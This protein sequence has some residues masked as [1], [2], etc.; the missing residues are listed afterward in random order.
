MPLTII[1]NDNIKDL[2]DKYII[3]QKNLPQPFRHKYIGEWDVSRVT[4]MSNLFNDSKY[5]AFNE[6]IN[7]WD[8]SNVTNMKSMFAGCIFFN[9]PLYKWKVSKVTDMSDMFNTCR[10]FNQDI[11]S[12]DVFN[13]KDM[14]RMFSSCDKLREKPNWVLNTETKT[15]NI[16]FK[17]AFE[18][19]DFERSDINIRKLERE[20]K[21][22]TMMT[23]ARSQE[24]TNAKWQK[25]INARSQSM[26]NASS[27]S[28]SNARSQ[29]LAITKTETFDSDYININELRPGV[30]YNFTYGIHIIEGTFVEVIDTNPRRL[31]YVFKDIYKF[32]FNRNTHVYEIEKKYSMN[33][34]FENL[35]RYIKIIHSELPGN[36]SKHINLVNVK[37]TDLNPGSRYIFT[38]DDKEYETEFIK[39]YGWQLEGTFLGKEEE[40][41]YF[42]DVKNLTDDGKSIKFVKFNNIN[43]SFKNFKEFIFTSVPREINDKIK[44][45]ITGLETLHRPTKTLTIQNGYLRQDILQDLVPGRRYILTTTMNG[46]E[47]RVQLR[48]IQKILPTGTVRETQYLFDKYNL[49][50]LPNLQVISKQNPNNEIFIGKFVDITDQKNMYSNYYENNNN[51]INN[52]TYTLTPMIEGGNGLKKTKCRNNKRR[53]RGTRKHYR[54]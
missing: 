4:D 44:S 45:Y 51:N 48:F 32:A 26:S 12:W 6:D 50:M 8:V 49:L 18:G 29:S 20:G 19:T 33:G 31:E 40:I 37:I 7:E 23:N 34:F 17:T 27:Q 54:L 16:F 15:E 30:R 53:I 28:M 25:M 11:S 42:A 21:N 38:L 43:N 9:K 35:I 36:P 47:H 52:V 41:Y 5:Y 46:K 39:K 24:M 3:D 10:N 22:T 1:T 14:S 2:V 13:V